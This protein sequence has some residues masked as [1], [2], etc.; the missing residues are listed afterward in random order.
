MPKQCLFGTQQLLD[1]WV[2]Y[3]IR[4]PFPFSLFI[5]RSIPSSGSDV[6]QAHPAHETPAN[7]P[8][9]T[10]TS[11]RSNSPQH[12]HIETTS[13]VRHSPP[14]AFSTLHLTS[15][16]AYGSSDPPRSTT[17]DEDSEGYVLSETRSSRRWVWLLNSC[18]KTCM[19]Q[20]HGS[21]VLIILSQ[22]LK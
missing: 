8:H 16:S 4:E 1:Y 6:S 13:A 14:P 22:K 7:V 12:P 11:Q 15:D 20:C 2:L 3:L 19:R 21:P 17:P 10:T 18:G 5:I 9:P